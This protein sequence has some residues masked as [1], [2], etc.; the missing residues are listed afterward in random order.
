M[1]AL[2]SF[3]VR[4]WLPESLGSLFAMAMNLRWT[5]D[6]RTV[7]LFRWLDV[8]AWERAGHEPMTMLSL[9][10]RARFEELAEDESFVA[11]LK[12]VEKDLREYLHEPRWFQQRPDASLRQVAYFSPEFG[13]GEALPTYSGGLGVLAGDHLK[14]ASDLGIPL[15]GVGLL[16]RQGYFRQRLNSEGWQRELYPAFDPHSMP[17][18]LLARDDE[19]LAVSVDLAG[20]PCVAHIWRARIGRVELLLLDCDVEENGPEERSV[21]HRLYSG[22]GEH[23]LRQEI[24]LGIGGVRALIAAGYEPDVF[25]SNEGHAGFMGLERV[26]ELIETAGLSFSEALEAVRATTI[27]TTHTPVPAG[28]DVYARDLMERYFASFAER[29]GTSFDEFMELGRVEGAPTNFNMAAMGL[30]LAARTNGVSK[31]HG[32]VSRALF[33]PLWPQVPVDEVPIGSMTNGVHVPTWLGPEIAD[34]LNPRFGPGWAERGEIRW[35]RLLEVPNAQLWNARERARE[36]LVYF[37]RE[38]LRSQMLERTGS[39]HEAAWTAT[40]FDPA[41]LT[42]GFARRFA[43]YKRAALMLTDPER[44]GRLLLSQERPVQIVVAGKAHPLDDAGKDLIRTIVHFSM[45]PE[46]RTRIAFLEDYDMATARVLTQGCDVWLNNPRRPLEACGTSGMKVVLN[47]GMNCSV[48]DGWWNE[49]YDGENGWAIGTTEISPDL[50]QQDQLDADSLYGVLEREVVPRFYDRGGA[51]LPRQWV[52]RIKSSMAGLAGFVSAD[53]MLRQYTTELYEPASRHGRDMA[54]GDLSRARALAEWK[55]GVAAAW[56]DVAITSVDGDTSAAEIGDE[57]SVTAVVSLGSLSAQDVSV[58]LV[59]GRVGPNG[60]LVDPS[61]QPM[62][63]DDAEGVSTYRGTVPVEGAG[64]YGF[65]VRAIP[66]HP[67]L[68]S[69]METG[70]V[71]WA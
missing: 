68:T 24:V 20:T 37:V 18:T 16:Y 66:T 61:I 63:P 69:P 3:T 46:M 33:N 36:R 11:A 14:A 29:C 38:R 17:L 49:C 65:T 7:D 30:R 45:D 5:W 13:V 44:L 31:L 41:A 53:R 4:A 22:A 25:H 15:V 43:P 27:F 70:L 58:Q 34:V 55:K 62:E 50:E 32:Q 71:T 6:R 35:E 39:E 47:G 57:R 56:G 9:V 21:T 54:P 23:R 60:E 67:D 52:E 2:K 8:E 64:R 12:T 1:R 10:P 19:P 51:V 28:I 40:A 26:R 59:H 48:L 42:I